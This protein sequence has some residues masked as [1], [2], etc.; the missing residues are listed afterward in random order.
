MSI[1]DKIKHRAEKAGR[2]IDKTAKDAGKAVAKTA[3]TAVGETKHAAVDARGKV[4][5]VGDDIQG[6]INRAGKEINGLKDQALHEIRDAQQQAQRGVVDTGKKV[7]GDLERGVTEQLPGLITKELPAALKAMAEGLASEA[8]K[9][10]LKL[11]A[12]GCRKWHAEM[13]AIRED[14]PDLIGYIE[15]LGF[16]ID[17]KVNA[18]LKLEYSGF[19]SRAQEVAGI[20]DRY[21]NSGIKPRRR[22][23]IGFVDATGPTTVDLGLSV[24]VSLGVDAG[25]KFE[26]P[27][28]PAKLFT[29]LGDR[30][31]KA[32]GVP[33]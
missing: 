10:A 3:E 30:A 23:I 26:L 16:V 22:D 19:Y 25:V 9:P 27:K 14:E 7:S 8:M 18:G 17:L 32:A 1:F 2:A 28:I 6:L 5:G 24:T 12:L 21:A 33:A 20:L 11:A 4:M 15:K 29:K 13:V 31:L